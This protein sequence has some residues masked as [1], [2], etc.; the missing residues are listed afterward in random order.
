MKSVINSTIAKHTGKLLTE[1][2]IMEISEELLDVLRYLENYGYNAI[3]KN[4]IDL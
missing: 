1:E 4:N 2:R 3:G